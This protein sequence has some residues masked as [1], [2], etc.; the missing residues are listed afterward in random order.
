[1]RWRRAS[2]RVGRAL[3]AF[4]KMRTEH[5]TARRILLWLLL[6]YLVLI[7]WALRPAD[8]L[9]TAEIN[10]EYVSFDVSDS[11]KAAFHLKG[12]KVA[13]LGQSGSCETGLF[14]PGLRTKVSYG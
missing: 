3:L 7:S 8:V 10:T 13:E 12:V 6:P 1:M 4:M 14:S 11:Q 5:G 9:S 2:G